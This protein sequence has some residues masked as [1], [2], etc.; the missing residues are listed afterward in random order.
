[1]RVQKALPEPSETMR[2][3][4]SE[5]IFDNNDL[6]YALAGSGVLNMASGSLFLQNRNSR[7]KAL[8]IPPSQ[9]VGPTV[10]LGQ[11]QGD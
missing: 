9:Q 6:P 5:D 10:Y 7:D 1:M 2:R 11:E 3:A 4:R 8:P